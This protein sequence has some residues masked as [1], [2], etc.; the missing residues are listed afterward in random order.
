MPEPANASPD[1]A[2]A[3][4]SLASF[5]TIG[6][7]LEWWNDGI[8]EYW[9]L[10]GRH[11]RHRLGAPLRAIGF[12]L[13]FTLHTS[14]FSRIGFVS[15]SGA[16]RRCRTTGPGAPPDVRRKIP[17]FLP[18]ESRP[19]RATCQIHTVPAPQNRV[20]RGASPEYQNT[21]IPHEPKRY[22]GFF[23]QKRHLQQRTGGLP[24]ASRR[25]AESSKLRRLREHAARLARLN[26]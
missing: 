24:L 4:P 10:H 11:G 15:R 22:S 9:A 7:G 8:L 25:S 26:T 5:R 19:P 16:S 20:F 3:S 17:S 2:L 13:Y 23:A 1:P 6:T 21:R 18:R 12:V 14:N